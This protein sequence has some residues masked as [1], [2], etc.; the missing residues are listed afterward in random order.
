MKQTI[1]RAAIAAA[2]AAAPSLAA[3]QK[4]PIS[5]P[6]G[7]SGPDCLV[8]G[9]SLAVELAKAMRRQGTICDVAARKG[10]TA[11]QI[12]AMAPMK[13]Y[14]V[15]YI[16]AGSNDPKAV[17]LEDDV[18][19]LRSHIKAPKVVWILPYNRIAA[20]SVSANAFESGGFIVDVAW[21]PTLD[22]LHPLDYTG[23]ATMIVK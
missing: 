20:R 9:D 23:L 11:K 18:R 22:G 4:S 6:F 5:N 1:L 15:A 3:A 8:I 19:M 7:A 12:D 14:S 2:I 13:H 10:A 16:S 17:R 21:W